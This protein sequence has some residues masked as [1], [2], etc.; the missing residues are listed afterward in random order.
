LKRRNKGD[1]AFYPFYFH[2]VASFSVF[3]EIIQEGG[4][5]TASG[6]SGIISRVN[7]DKHIYRLS[8]LPGN[9]RSTDFSIAEVRTS[10]TG[11]HK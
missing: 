9:R 4:Y 11:T 2:N 8:A 5:L 3:S 6:F 10:T 1:N 7:F